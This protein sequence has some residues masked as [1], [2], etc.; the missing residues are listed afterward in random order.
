[1][2]RRRK[3]ELLFVVLGGLY[4]SIAVSNIGDPVRRAFWQWVTPAALVGLVVFI[5]AADFLVQRR[6]AIRRTGLSDGPTAAP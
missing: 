1:M 2:F 6:R 3:S 5:I 4:L